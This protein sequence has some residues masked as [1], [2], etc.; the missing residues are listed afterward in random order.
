[1]TI[2]VTQE[3]IDKGCPGSNLLC[4]VAEALK[5]A[6]GVNWS[7]GR[8]AGGPLDGTDR[9]FDFG[10]DVGKFTSA[11]DRR[12]SVAPFEFELKDWR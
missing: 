11:F 9:R 6:T 12:A 7:V 2:R 10:D 8:N 3:H 1:M 4:P 5:E